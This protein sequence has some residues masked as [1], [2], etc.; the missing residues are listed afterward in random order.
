[1][2]RWIILAV[3]G[4][5]LGACGESPK[6]ATAAPTAAEADHDH[7]ASDG[8]DHEKS[9]KGGDEHDHEEH[10]HEHEEGEPDFAKI[11][12]ARATELGIGVATAAGGNVD[13]VLTLTGRLII[14][15]RRVAAVRARFP[16][17]VI[18]VLRE[19]GDPVKRG[20]ALARVESNE[21]LTTYYV[22]APLGGVVLARNTNV[23]DVAGTD[24][25][26]TVGDVSALQAEL[27]AFG[28]AT[29]RLRVGTLVRIET[30]GQITKGRITSIA[31][32]LEARTQARRV[33]VSIDDDTR[34]AGAP[35]QFVTA[36]VASGVAKAAAVVVP[37]DAVRQLEA[38]DVVFIPEENGFR[39]RPVTIGRRGL[40][41][42]EIVDGL[43][44]GEQ[45]VSGGSFVLKAEIGKNLA[46][47]EH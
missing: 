2:N 34:L 46:E 33:R 21:S 45:Y 3:L 11:D 36:Q 31:P 14:D 8:H 4:L 47:H 7:E 42:L 37:I 20:Q 1:M 17:P 28:A 23:G 9:E 27:Q 30:D 13:E 39:A 15:P 40:T 32:E 6:K 25:L 12:P 44:A 19:V 18:A 35:G 24:A 16:G 41:V 43:D 26:F 22:S 10:E 38:R 5:A 29:T